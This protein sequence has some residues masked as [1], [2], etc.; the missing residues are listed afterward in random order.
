MKIFRLIIC[1][2]ISLAF[3][4]AVS[5]N[6]FEVQGE[7]QFRLKQTNVAKTIRLTIANGEI[8]ANGVSFDPSLFCPSTANDPRM[9]PDG[10]VSVTNAGVSVEV[11]QVFLIRPSQTPDGKARIGNPGDAG[12]GLI[13]KSRAIESLSLKNEIRSTLP[14]P[15]GKTAIIQVN[16]LTEV[17]SPNINLAQVA[18]LGGAPELV[19]KLRTVSLGATPVI[20]SDRILT[21]ITIQSA[22]RTARIPMDKIEIIVPP[23]AKVR[24]ESR[25]VSPSEIE[26]FGRD[27]IAQ[28]LPEAGAVSL[29]TKPLERKIATGE[30]VV[31]VS[32]PRDVG[33]SII[34][35]LTCKIGDETQFAQQLVFN[36]G[37]S[38]TLPTIK[39]GATVQVR[40]ISGGISIE[41]TGQVKAVSGDN[42][43]VFIPETKATLVGKLNADGTIEVKL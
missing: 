34:V 36:K 41:V 18:E 37:I 10:W 12:F 20:G 22:L 19:S 11:G 31:T 33:K 14:V 1:F 43:T 32:S 29:I 24:R 28:N 13:V 2:A 25:T 3:S 7:G 21:V 6:S 26:K 4:G 5:Q 40:L 27:W 35:T 17:N 38:A 8:K 39:S 15:S 23:L 30:L 16:A 9:S 42:V